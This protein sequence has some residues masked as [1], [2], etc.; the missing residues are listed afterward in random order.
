MKDSELNDDFRDLLLAFADAEVEFVVVGAHAVGYHGLPRATRDLDVF[1]RPSADNARRVYG[2]LARFGAPLASTG[3]TPAD[4]ESRG[5]VYQI[6]VAPR[7][8]DVLTE[9]SGVSFDEALVGR[10]TLVLEGRSIPYIGRAALIRNKEASGRPQ[11]LTDVERLRRQKP[12][13]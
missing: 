11:D 2:A 10:G 13:R 4:F 5:T 7:R 3:V 8:I 12:G 6:G 1:V 9:I